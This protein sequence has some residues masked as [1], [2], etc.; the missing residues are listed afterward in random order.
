LGN[1]RAAAVK[2]WFAAQGLG[3]ARFSIVSY[4]EERPADPRSNEEAWARNRRA[5]FRIARSAR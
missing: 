3:E 2:Q 5:E 1:R 4:G